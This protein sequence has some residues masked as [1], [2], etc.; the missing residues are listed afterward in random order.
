MVRSFLADLLTQD[1]SHWIRL[2]LAILSPK[3][4]L[5]KVKGSDV[6]CL[7]LHQASQ[8]TRYNFT[9]ANWGGVKELLQ[10]CDCFPT[11]KGMSRPSRDVLWSGLYE[12]FVPAAYKYD[13]SLVLII[14]YLHLIAHNFRN[15]LCWGKKKP[16]PWHLG[17]L[18]N[19]SCWLQSIKQFWL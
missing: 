16:L 12:L 7:P 13:L 1:W 15:Y 6:P 9:Q 11:P 5:C 8:R 18:L 17:P 14:V 19:C 3:L 10:D 2:Q 4:V